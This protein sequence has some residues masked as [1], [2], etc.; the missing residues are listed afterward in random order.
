MDIA[1]SFRTLETLVSPGPNGLRDLEWEWLV[2]LL[3]KEAQ[4][5][6]K[7][8]WDRFCNLLKKGVQDLQPP[9]QK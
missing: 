2:I 6:H 1:I 3:T 7:D 9:Q 5:Q 8:L 4:A